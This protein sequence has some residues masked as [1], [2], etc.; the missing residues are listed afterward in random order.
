MPSNSKAYNKKNYSK[1]WGTESA[2]KD[3]AQRNKARRIAI[4]AGTAKKGDGKDVDHIKP[5]SK[6]GTTTKGNLRVVSAK[7]NRGKLNPRHK[8]T[9]KS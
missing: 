9:K 3:R 4:K 8:K 6:G 1:Y 5:I 7:S 2:K